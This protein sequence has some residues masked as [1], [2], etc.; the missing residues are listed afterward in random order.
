MSKAIPHFS[1]TLF[2]LLYFRK[3]LSDFFHCY[4]PG[5]YTQYSWELDSGEE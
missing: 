1:Q 2:Q 5:V 4:T 3:Q